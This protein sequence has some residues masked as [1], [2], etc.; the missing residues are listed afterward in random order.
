VVESALLF[1]SPLRVAEC[2]PH[3]GTLPQ[4]HSFFSVDDNRFVLSALKQAEKEEALILR[5]FNP[6]REDM[7]VTIT[8]PEN[9][10][11][12]EQVTLE[13]KSLHPLEV[14]DGAVSL[15]VGRGEIVNLLLK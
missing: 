11:A 7:E 12:A 6:T 8:V 2:T 5:G 9:I 1:N 10:G 15:K 13:E 4:T 14:A 3:K